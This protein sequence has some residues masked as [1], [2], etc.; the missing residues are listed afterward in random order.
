VTG[1]SE[2]QGGATAGCGDCR[3]WHPL[4]LEDFA[5]QHVEC[6]SRFVRFC[7]CL[8]QLFFYLSYFFTDRNAGMTGWLASVTSHLILHIWTECRRQPL[9]ERLVRGR[10]FFSSAWET[11]GTGVGSGAVLAMYTWCRATKSGPEDGRLMRS[12]GE[13]DWERGERGR[14]G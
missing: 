11:A 6:R 7:S 12:V 3:S 14:K 5:G 10:E 2:Q 13:Y 8:T 9:G 4:T 1:R